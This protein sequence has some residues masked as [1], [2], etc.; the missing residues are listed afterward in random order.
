MADNPKDRGKQD[1]A[2]V[3]SSEDYEVDYLAQKLGVTADQVRQA[4]QKVGKSRSKIEDYLRKQ[5]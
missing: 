5:V 1:R 3:N 2:Q 4:E